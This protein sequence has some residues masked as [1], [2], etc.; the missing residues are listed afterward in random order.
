MIL[1]QAAPSR[2]RLSVALTSTTRRGRTSLVSSVRALGVA[3]RL[4][5]RHPL[6]MVSSCVAVDRVGHQRTDEVRLKLEK[7][8]SVQISRCW[9]TRTSDLFKRAN[10]SVAPATAALPLK[11]LTE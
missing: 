6:H 10:G 1:E 8:I 4:D 9:A 2:R 11:P 7:V 5:D 3:R